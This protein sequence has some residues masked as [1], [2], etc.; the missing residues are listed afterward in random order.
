MHSTASQARW[1]ARPDRIQGQLSIVSKRNINSPST[2][3]FVC[4]STSSNDDALLRQKAKAL[5][6]LFYSSSENVSSTDNAAEDPARE[7]LLSLPGVIPDLPLWRVQWAVLPSYQE[8]LHVHVPHYTDLFS[9]LFTQKRP[10]RFGHLYL[11]GGSASL[12]SEAYAL[13]NGSN[14]PLV[15]TLME[16]I[17]AVR[18]PDGR[19]LI[20]AAGVGRFKVLNTLQTVPASRA[21]VMLLPDEEELESVSENA[22]KSLEQL[23]KSK[24]Y[25]LSVMKAMH[26]VDAA[27]QHAA[28][29]AAK[30]W[31]E[32]E[33]MHCRVHEKL[34]VID[35]S[36]N[37][38][39]AMQF[40]RR[41]VRS[42]PSAERYCI[43][44]LN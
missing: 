40:G 4:R 34:A 22:T 31:W 8:V 25:E 7:A 23:T 14:A 9:R 6:L 2:S 1:L 43:N 39:A 29:N 30:S 18:F 21:D 38:T 24:H 32:Y 37:E 19:L 33:L 15:G 5:E 26:A 12:G 20:L 11:P 35:S 27:A 13:Q 3:R 41:L 10:W 28:A 17:Q 16:I 36:D 42:I 44:N